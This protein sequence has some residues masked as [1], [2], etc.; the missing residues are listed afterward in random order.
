MGDAWRLEDVAI[1]A[2]ACSIRT[3]VM[4]LSG[5]LEIPRLK[6]KQSLGCRRNSCNSGPRAGI[7]RKRRESILDAE[8]S[9][10]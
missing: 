7:Q 6:A 10:A 1:R 9:P 2:S 3:D 8:S 4:S 5:M